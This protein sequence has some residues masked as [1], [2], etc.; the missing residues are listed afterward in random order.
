MFFFSSR[1]RH[2]RCALVTG[3]Q[4][5]ALPIS[6]DLTKAG[7][8]F[9]TR[10]TLADYCSTSAERHHSAERLFQMI[11]SGALRADAGRRLALRDAASSPRALASRATTGSTVLVPRAASGGRQRHQSPPGIGSSDKRRL[12][13]E[14][15]RD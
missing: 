5:C 3:V 11:A 12:G 15:F 7:S 9:M 10:P 6:L 2:T 13:N 8:V 1:R 4:T 14:R